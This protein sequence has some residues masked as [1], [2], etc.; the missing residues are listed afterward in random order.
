MKFSIAFCLLVIACSACAF[1][2]TYT[3]GESGLSATIPDSDLSGVQRTVLV[4]G[5][6][7]P[8]TDVNFAL[9]LSGGFNGDFYG[10]ITH[11]SSTRF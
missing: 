10:F 6:E 8:I 1:N 3:F 2:V 4:S 5:F 9:N 11:G 7:G